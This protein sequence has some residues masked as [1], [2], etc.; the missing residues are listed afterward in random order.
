MLHVLGVFQDGEMFLVGHQQPW[1][2]VAK[3][4]VDLSTPVTEIHGR[5]NCACAHHGKISHNIFRSVAKKN[6]DS[7]ARS[8]SPRDQACGEAIDGVE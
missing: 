8:Q 5:S 2:T 1:R 4:M 7:I 3:D 6:G